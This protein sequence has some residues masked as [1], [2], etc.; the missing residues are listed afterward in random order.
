MTKSN[1]RNVS[2]LPNPSKI[3]KKV[4]SIQLSDYFDRIFDDFLCAF[5]KG[6]GYQNTLLRLFEDWKML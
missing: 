6:H 4:L 5:R 1:N 2:L 3:F